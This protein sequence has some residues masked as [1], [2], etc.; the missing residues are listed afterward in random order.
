MPNDKKDID[1]PEV[2]R[3][4]FIL[5]LQLSAAVNALNSCYCSKDGEQELCNRYGFI[6]GLVEDLAEECSPMALEDAINVLT[7]A[8]HEK[9]RA[10][11]AK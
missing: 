10:P 6:Q 3:T 4:R 9:K 1:V 5:K 11:D 7:L 2:S 8:Y